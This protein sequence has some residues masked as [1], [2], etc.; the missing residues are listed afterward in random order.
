MSPGQFRSGWVLLPGVLTPQVVIAP[1]VWPANAA[2]VNS[3]LFNA[4]LHGASY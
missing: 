4:Q 3:G 1:G 2:A